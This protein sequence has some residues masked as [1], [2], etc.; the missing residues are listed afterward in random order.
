M[1]AV[2][3]DSG[4]A[5]G[6]PTQLPRQLLS[7]RRQPLNSTWIPLLRLKESYDMLFFLLLEVL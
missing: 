7:L 3:Q 5:V 6:A 2:V 1:F 4:T